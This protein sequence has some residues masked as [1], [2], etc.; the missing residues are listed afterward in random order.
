MSTAPQRY[1]I[2]AADYLAG[3]LVSNQKHEFVDGTVYAMAGAPARHNRIATN[4]TIAIGS[5]LRG[6]PCEAFNSDMKIRIRRGRGEK[7]YYP[8]MSVVCQPNPDKDMF[9][10]RP[11]VVV[12]VLSDSTRR[13]D[14]YEKRE[15]YFMIDSLKCYILIEQNRQ[16]ALV[17]RRGDTGFEREIYE[18]LEAVI[19]LFEIGCELSLG[20]AYANVSFS[21]T[22][23]GE[24]D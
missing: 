20:E 9:H 13:A 17:Y 1:P 6:K 4:I 18:G 24:G 3:E 2:S 15:T 11:V 14:E 5:Q 10:D 21:I 7:Y 23:V 12:E 22:D 19:P 8:D 16:L